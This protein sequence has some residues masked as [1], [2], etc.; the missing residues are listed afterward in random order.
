[1]FTN[2]I[3]GYL[4]QAERAQRAQQ[5]R[6]GFVAI[7]GH[8]PGRALPFASAQDLYRYAYECAKA[9]LLNQL[10]TLLR[11]RWDLMHVIGDDLSV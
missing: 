7:P 4:E 11:S 9:E 1:M 10:V 5:T 6:P 8:M 3:T 2:R